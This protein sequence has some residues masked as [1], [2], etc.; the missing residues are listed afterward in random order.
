LYSQKQI[1]E[2]SRVSKDKWLEVYILDFYDNKKSTNVPTKHKVLGTSKFN[3]SIWYSQQ[4]FI[5][6][7]GTVDG[8]AEGLPD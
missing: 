3:L 7:H 1:E 5:D 4:L 8:N 2:H 6:F